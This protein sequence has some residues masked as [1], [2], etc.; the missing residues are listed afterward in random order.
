[1]R[2]II[3]F[4]VMSLICSTG[5]AQKITGTL[6][7]IADTGTFTIGYR[8]DSKPFSYLDSSGVPIGYSIDLCKRIAVA[9]R[10]SLGL[11]KLDIKYVKVS[12]KDRFDAVES[13][14]VDIEC[15]ATTITLSRLER[16]DF[17]MMTFVTGGSL[18]SKK[19]DPITMTGDLG[20]KSVAVLKN[21]TTVV[22]LKEYLRESLI[23]ETIIEVNNG[24][25]G[26]E[27]LESGKVQALAR[28]QVVL[29]GQVLK[30]VDPKEYVLSQDLFSFEPYGFMIRR[31]DSAFRLVTNRSLAQ[32]YRTE[33]YQPLYN[34]WFGS[35]G[36]RP[37]PVLAAM[38]KMQSLPE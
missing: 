16:V 30:T 20:G 25:E 14:K 27:Q 4:I 8:D 28:D 3:F 15:G 23:D 24:S 18:L 38:Y 9:T 29:I 7:K 1:M 17:T 36:V 19:S 11:A 10:E 6:K 26:M 34:K 12:A 35:A 5:F 21:T 31:N 37:S 33:Q 22:A 32:L 2:R 13:G